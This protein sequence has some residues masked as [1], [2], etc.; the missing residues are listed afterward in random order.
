M[1][2]IVFGSPEAK[3]IVEFDLAVRL[4][5]KELREIPS[6]FLPYILGSEVKDCIYFLA[7]SEYEHAL[8]KRAWRYMLKT[9]RWIL[10]QYGSKRS[11]N[12]YQPVDE[13]E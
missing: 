6:D 10:F 9:K 4:L 2:A 7:D 12:R 8:F 3:K 5:D 11:G 13:E 1:S